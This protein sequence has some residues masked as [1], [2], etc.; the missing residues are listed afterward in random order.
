MSQKA[1]SADITIIGGGIAGL[2]LAALLGDMDINVHLVEPFP[3][4]PIKDLKP[5]GRTVAL[6]E[7]SLNIIKTTDIWNDI[8]DQCAPIKMMRVIDP[9]SKTREILQTDFPA[10]DIDQDQ[11]GHNIPNALLRTT[12][13]QRVKALKSVTLHESKLSSLNNAP[14]H[15]DLILDNGAEIKSPLLIGA[16]GRSSKVRELLGIQTK[17][18][19]YDQ[20]AI[21]CLINHS[22]SHE[23]IS[24]EFHHPAGPLALVPLPGNQ[25]SIVWVEQPKRAGALLKL[26]KTEFERALQSAMNDHLGGIT[27]EAGPDMWPLSSIKAEALIAPR[28]ALIAEAAHV[29]SP[30]TAQGLNLSLRDVA[31]LAETIVDAMRLGLDHGSATT[32]KQYEKRR[33][34]DIGT[35]VFGVDGMNKMVSNNVPAIKGLPRAGLKTLSALPPLKR[36]AMEQALAPPIDKSRLAKGEAL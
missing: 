26:K 5:S 27:L 19:K 36:F 28:A 9:A 23:N 7:N 4:P 11:F 10:S 32:L 13:W 15:V 14:N 17:A 35:R 21:T 33:R 2:T 1:H 12:L 6:M 30:I 22:K 24:T 34:L 3:P 25:S 20:N 18:Q 31:A 16:D 8:K 29:M